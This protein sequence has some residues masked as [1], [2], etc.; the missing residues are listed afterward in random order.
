MT[1]TWGFLFQ[2]GVTPGMLFRCGLDSGSE[3]TV[4]M[5]PLSEQELLAEVVGKS[6]SHFH[7]FLCELDEIRVC[8]S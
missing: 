2:I 4:E 1:F 6:R 8:A 7:F 5:S 3:I